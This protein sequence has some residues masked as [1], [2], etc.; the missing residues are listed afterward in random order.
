MT[1]HAAVV[2]ALTAGR[3]RFDAEQTFDRGAPGPVD[4]Q[5]FHL[6]VTGPRVTMPGTEIFGVFP[7]PNAQGPFTGRFPQ[8]VFKRR[9]MPWERSTDTTPWMALVVFADGE[10]SFLP[11]VDIADAYS[12]G[13]AS[14]LPFLPEDVT[15][16]AI[17]VPQSVL[18]R[19]F[20]ARAELHLLSHVREVDVSDTENADADG[21]VS[22][23]IANRLPQPGQAYRAC[24]L[25][26]EG[27]LG[28]LPNPGVPTDAPTRTSAFE[29][30]VTEAQR[31]E[32]F[33]RRHFGDDT[34]TF[35][36]GGDRTVRRTGGSIALG[37]APSHYGHGVA[38]DLDLTAFEAI[39]SVGN[40]YRFPVLAQWEFT[41]ADLDGDFRGYMEHLAV[42]LLGASDGAV[43]PVRERAPTV[44]ATGHVE[45]SHTDRRG[46]TRPAWYR[47]PITP[48]KIT[49]KPAGQP[50]HVVDQA[51]RITTDGRVDVSHMSAFELGR[52]LAMSDLQFLQDLRSWAADDFRVHRERS[53]LDDRLHDLG[54]AFEFDRL[55]DIRLV[56]EVLGPR[57]IGGDPHEKLGQ[58]VPIHHAA[59]LV[60]PGDVDVLATGLHV[61]RTAVTAALD[62]G[63]SAAPVDPGVGVGIDPRL[64]GDLRRLLG[65]RGV[66]EI[67]DVGLAD[68]LQ[69]REASLD[70]IEMLL[71][72][73]VDLGTVGDLFGRNP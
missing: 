26:L 65:D 53:L 43:D 29:G 73:G 67:L 46:E 60:D 66:N 58:P 48:A 37:S 64:G 21:W 15:C 56:A 44:A 22:V 47:G 55:V 39:V 61:T 30:L 62:P 38:L 7:P 10:A 23:V 8:I 72:N 17:E 34:V 31:T 52:L 49:R 1:L 35:V 18:D 42:G 19:V 2:P 69:L 71:D 51:R 24:L 5:A 41:N 28:S 57:G 20:P 12:D 6:E 59:T 40:R 36:N 63:L 54:V 14:T 16:D 68:S 32:I 50:Y 13:V 3:Y 9:T 11:G 45:I 27:Q 33:H 4:T 70:R 25:S